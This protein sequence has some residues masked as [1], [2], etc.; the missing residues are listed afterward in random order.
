M[1]APLWQYAARGD[2]E[3]VDRITSSPEGRGRID[4]ERDKVRMTGARINEYTLGRFVTISLVVSMS[5][6]LS[7]SVHVPLLAF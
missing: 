7:V 6:P 2:E 5:S 3:S 4:T 1:H